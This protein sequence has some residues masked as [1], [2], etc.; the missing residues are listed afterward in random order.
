MLE[1]GILQSG[2]SPAGVFLVD[3]IEK[4][5]CLTSNFIQDKDE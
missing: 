4:A 3:G 2:R 1:D 5:E